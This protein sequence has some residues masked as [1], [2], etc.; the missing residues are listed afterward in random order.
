MLYVQPASIQFIEW[1]LK[2]M[3]EPSIVHDILWQ[4][5]SALREHPVQQMAAKVKAKVEKAQ[6]ND[7]VL[8]I[9]AKS[10]IF[11]L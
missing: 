11:N 9:P 5:N 7:K 10:V 8:L 4:F 6:K 2:N 1:L 3:S